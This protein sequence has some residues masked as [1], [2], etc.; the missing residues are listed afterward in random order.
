M[1]EGKR[2]EEGRRVGKTIYINENNFKNQ[3]MTKTT[4]FLESHPRNHC[5]VGLLTLACTP[6]RSDQVS[7]KQEF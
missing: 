2:G 1:G 4:D 3:E 6:R 5:T 7:V